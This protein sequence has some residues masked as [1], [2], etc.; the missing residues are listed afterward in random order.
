M[1]QSNKISKAIRAGVT[2]MGF[3][4][5]AFYV[6]ICAIVGGVALLIAEAIDSKTDSTQ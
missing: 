6:P 5:C 2:T 1:E 3:F 4:A